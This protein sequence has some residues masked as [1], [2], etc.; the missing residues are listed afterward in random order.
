M[1]EVLGS[2]VDGRGRASEH[3]AEFNEALRVVSGQIFH[4]GSLNVVLERPLRL[5]PDVGVAFDEWGKRRLWSGR[6]NGDRVWIY[7]W[8][9]CPLHIVEVLH[10]DLLRKRLQLRTG[11][12]I[13]LELD[14]AARP[15]VIDRLF[16][17]CLWA[18]GRRGWFYTRP[19]YARL[20][21]RLDRGLLTQQR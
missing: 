12:I 20:V 3:L 1:T 6:L 10:P 2:V 17:G 13:R 5:R 21:A 4:P 18:L 7:R 11:S 15:S 14:G 9:G 8:R 19:E 16:W